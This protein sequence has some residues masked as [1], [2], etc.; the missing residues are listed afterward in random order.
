MR[1]N[2]FLRFADGTA[3]FSACLSDPHSLSQHPRTHRRPLFLKKL[4]QKKPHFSKNSRKI[5]VD[6]YQSKTRSNPSFFLCKENSRK[7]N[8]KKNKTGNLCWEMNITMNKF[9][10]ERINWRKERWKKIDGKINWLKFRE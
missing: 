7:V 6:E 1:S 5:I 2:G 9:F 8:E 4:P 3:T 10:F